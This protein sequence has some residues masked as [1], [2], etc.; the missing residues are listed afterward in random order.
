[1]EITRVLQGIASLPNGFGGLDLEFLALLQKRSRNLALASEIGHRLVRSR[2]AIL[3]SS[4]PEL[5]EPI[6]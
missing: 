2:Q 3:A 5:R 1:L 4:R 6:T